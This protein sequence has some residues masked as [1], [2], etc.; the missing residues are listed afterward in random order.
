MFVVNSKKFRQHRNW[1]TAY[2]RV[3]FKLTIQSKNM[4]NNEFGEA[5]N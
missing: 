3:R 4:Y 5:E 1:S 2:S